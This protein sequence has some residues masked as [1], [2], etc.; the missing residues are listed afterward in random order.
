M[1][2]Q[3]TD[4]QIREEV[5]FL[6]I[7]LDQESNWTE[8]ANYQNNH[9]LGDIWYS[10]FLNGSKYQPVVEKESKICLKQFVRRKLQ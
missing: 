2:L 10:Q 4:T 7:S 8:K 1:I 5:Y 6:W 9:Q 3:W